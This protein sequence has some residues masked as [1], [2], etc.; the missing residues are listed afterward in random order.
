M[1]KIFHTVS[2][3]KVGNPEILERYL[4]DLGQRKPGDKKPLEISTS[5]YTA[6][7]DVVTDVVT[8]IDL[9]HDGQ[10]DVI[11]GRSYRTNSGASDKSCRWVTFTSVYFGAADKIYSTD[12]TPKISGNPDIVDATILE[13]MPT[14]DRW[15][16]SAAMMVSAGADHDRMEKN[17]A[18]AVH[19]LMTFCYNSLDYFEIA[20]ITRTDLA[21]DAIASNDVLKKMLGVD[22]G[23]AIPALERRI[24]KEKSSY[25]SRLRSILRE[26]K[27]RPDPEGRGLAYDKWVNP[28][29]L[30]GEA[31]HDALYREL[32]QKTHAEAKPQ[33]EAEYLRNRA[34]FLDQ[35][36]MQGGLFE[37]GPDGFIA[38]ANTMAKKSGF[39]NYAEMAM[40]QDYGISVGDFKKMAF[41]RL[42]RNKEYIAASMK[43]IREFVVP[44]RPIWELNT[45]DLFGEKKVRALKGVHVEKEPTLSIEEAI[46]V[47]KAFFKDM[48][49]DLDN[50]PTGKKIVFDVSEREKKDEGAF[51]LHNGDG[52]INVLSLLSWRKDRR[53]EVLQL[54]SLFHEIGH[55]IHYLYASKNS[56]R[57][58][59]GGAGSNSIG[60]RETFAD[61]FK[62]IILTKEFADKY[63]AKYEEFKNPEARR[64]LLAESSEWQIF[65]DSVLLARALWEINLYEHADES[66]DDRLNYWGELGQRC[67][68]G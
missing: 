16:N 17:V 53:I 6:Q 9:N 36:R 3:A 41:G 22:L 20:Q 12:S 32:L 64:V 33:D 14:Q 50:L 45:W 2:Q 7:M 60:L 39:A 28:K 4:E 59:F 57:S 27:R 62:G 40:M 63:L 10:N 13:A 26:L 56:G 51:Q 34:Y 52:S 25:T 23:F 42:A 44:E 24:K 55:A 8:D 66:M 19:S 47:A 65:W 46:D 61:F 49:C 43:K 21:K 54:S 67:L 18:A 68:S 58:Y 48:G 35:Q 15:E 11:V 38:K 30:T 37:E 31:L 5:S 29:K 1:S